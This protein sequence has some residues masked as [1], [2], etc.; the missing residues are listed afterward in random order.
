MAIS[1]VAAYSSG[2]TALDALSTATLSS[3]R[4][5][6]SRNS[7]TPVPKGASGCGS[8]TQS[9]GALSENRPWGS[10][11]AT[12]VGAT[13]VWAGAPAPG[14]APGEAAA[15]ADGFAA[16]TAG[17]GVAG[18]PCAGTVGTTRAKVAT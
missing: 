10:R 6:G 13:P 9:V 17:V 5:L 15:T 3:A 4:P 7:T 18:R 11:Q 12:S 1:M 14:V 2:E 16:A 8:V